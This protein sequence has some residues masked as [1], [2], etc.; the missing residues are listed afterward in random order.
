MSVSTGKLYT[1]FDQ[2]MAPVRSL[3]G[4][5]EMN[6]RGRMETRTKSFDTH[7]CMLPRIDDTSSR[8]PGTSGPIRPF[9]GHHGTAGVWTLP[10]AC[11]RLYLELPVAGNARKHAAGGGG[12]PLTIYIS[13]SWPVLIFPISHII[14]SLKSPPLL[15][16]RNNY[17]TDVFHYDHFKRN[18]R[19]L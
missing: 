4:P 7:G 3:K 12:G 1:L 19:P 2:L 11:I 15:S 6:L 10:D 16:P 18:Q 14:T 17:S 9:V 13:A 8:E 5:M